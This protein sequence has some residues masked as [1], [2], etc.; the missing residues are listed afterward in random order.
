MKKVLSALFLVFSLTCSAQ[1]QK[2]YES[3]DTLAG[4]Q[5]LYFTD[6]NRGFIVG[7]DTF[8]SS[9]YI[10]SSTDGFDSWI[11][12]YFPQAFI[13]SVDFPTVDTGYVTGIFNTRIFVMR[14]VDNGQT[15]DLIN[16]SV[17]F[18]NP[19]SVDISFFNDSVGIVSVDNAAFITH[20]SGN[21]WSQISA[22]PPIGAR[23]VD[24]LGS[25]YAAAN[26]SILRYSNDYGQNF[27][28]TLVYDN[29]SCD[30]IELWDDK[31]IIVGQA[32]VNQTPEFPFFN[33]AR[34]AIGTFPNINMTRYEFPYIRDITDVERVSDG[35][36][37]AVTFPYPYPTLLQKHFLK[38]I[39]GGNTWY[40]QS[41][42]PQDEVPYT[43]LDNIF[44]I[45]DTLCY[46]AFGGV[47][48]KTTN[49]GGPLL[50][51]VTQV[52]LSVAGIK[53]DLNFSMAPNPTKG[54]VTIK[55]EKEQI[56]R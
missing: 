45:N 30:E 15:W 44:C 37:Y 38:S 27:D 42:Y 33:Y 12:D 53:D 4:H 49:G 14:T 43:R 40:V 24:I 51:E 20:D 46:V 28:A 2:I 13:R 34:I 48:Y 16:D 39:D 50:E 5:D 18:A 10:M 47:I 1:W 35:S 52:P 3:T 22:D 19:P 8:Q 36:I 26:G 11:V 32:G 41:T 55:S 6:A 7:Y 31:F 29:T 23:G 56:K 17:V 25:R 9:G 54:M 21:N